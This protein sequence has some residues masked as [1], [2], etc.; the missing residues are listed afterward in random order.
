MVEGVE[1]KMV[2]APLH[3]GVVK[4]CGHCVGRRSLFIFPEFGA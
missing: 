2:T 4:K 3:A 1:K